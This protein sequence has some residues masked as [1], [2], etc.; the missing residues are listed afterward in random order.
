M[1]SKKFRASEAISYS[2]QLN[3][4]PIV[5]DFPLLYPYMTI[6]KRHTQSAK[7]FGFLVFGYKKT[8]RYG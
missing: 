8:N 3:F 7:H 2:P 5:R 4:E 6:N 1:H